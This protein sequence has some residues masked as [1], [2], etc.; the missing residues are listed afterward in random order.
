MWCGLILEKF[1]KIIFLFVQYS[2]HNRLSR[3]AAFLPIR[4]DEL[5][6]NNILIIIQR[7]LTYFKVLNKLQ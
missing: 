6:T 7:L 2:Y 1:N 3:F 5:N 4:V